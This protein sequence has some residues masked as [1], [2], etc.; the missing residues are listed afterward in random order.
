MAGGAGTLRAQQSACPVGG[1][2][3]IWK[4]ITRSDLGNLVRAA[5]RADLTERQ[6]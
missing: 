5:P 3:I 2:D 4:D 1:W 6:L